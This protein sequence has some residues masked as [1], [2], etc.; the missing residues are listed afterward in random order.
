M[1]AFGIS[2]KELRIFLERSL[3]KREK[4]LFLILN[5]YQGIT[6][7]AAVRRIVDRDYPESTVKYVLYRLKKFKLVDFGDQNTKGK[8]LTFTDLG[9]TF[10]KILRGGEK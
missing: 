5:Q 2:R 10:F 8:P 4:E 1:V 6:F 9:N 3:R 7:S